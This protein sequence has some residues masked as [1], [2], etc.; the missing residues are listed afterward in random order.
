MIKTT[1]PLQIAIALLFGI[2]VLGNGFHWSSLFLLIAT[3]LMTPIPAFRKKAKTSLLVTLSIIFF[4]IGLLCSPL[5]ET[6]NVSE[7]DHT[8]EW[9][10]ATCET[11]QICDVCGNINGEKLEHDWNEATCTQ[12]QKCVACGK[13][14]GSALGHQWTT[15]TCSS[16]KTCNICKA[17]EGEKLEHDWNE[18][19]CTQAQKC[20]ACGKTQGSA[21]GHQ[22]TTAT[23]SSPKTCNICKATEGEKLEHNWNSLICTDEKKCTLCEEEKAPTEHTYID[24]KC[25]VCGTNKPSDPKP[26]KSTLTVQFIDVGQADSALIECDGHYMLIDGGNVA[27]SNVIYSILKKNGI[28]HLDI[29]VGTHAHEDHIGGLSGAF[30]YATSDLTLCPI[31]DYDSKAFNNFKTYA[32][33]KGGGIT[34]PSVGDKYKLGSATITILG[35]NSGNDTNDTSIVLRI[36]HGSISFL[37]TGD[38][39]REAEQFILNS[40]ANLSATVLKVGHHGSETSTT[41][42]FL[43]EIM[44]QYAIISVGKDNSYGHPTENTLSRLRDADVKLFRTDMQGDIF[45]TSD[46]NSIVF[47]VSKNANADVFGGI[48]DNSQG[49]DPTPIPTP[50]PDNDSNSKMV[51]IPQSGSKYHSNSDCSNMKNPTKVTIE[52]AIKQGYE[53]CKRCH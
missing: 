25:N 2:C 52:E 28:S 17:T 43:N 47:T 35:V 31:K 33:Q 4:F 38:A 50:T 14:Q 27:D 30:Q 7:S 9:K 21:L 42:P 48:G 45:C 6:D 12:A 15:A 11:P 44:P 1:K 46:G 18:A 53:P 51:W 37:F 10:E 19:T 24:G 39:E 32:D 41:Y 16:P 13:T 26:E 5:A 36:D 3:V 34:V 23:C 29:V 22:W 49:G 40:N 20:V 8:H